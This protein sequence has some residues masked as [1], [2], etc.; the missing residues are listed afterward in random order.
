MN[1][2]ILQN[3][4]W[5]EKILITKCSLDGQNICQIIAHLEKIYTTISSLGGQNIS[6]KM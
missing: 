6:Y 5:L 1:K 4:V 2:Y 3:A